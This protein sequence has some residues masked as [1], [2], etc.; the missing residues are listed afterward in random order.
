MKDDP[1]VPGFEVGAR[2]LQGC[3][4]FVT[5]CVTDPELPRYTRSTTFIEDNSGNN[6]MRFNRA[7]TFTFVLAFI[8]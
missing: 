1:A 6:L 4:I 2:V 8:V 7:N 5:G 3:I